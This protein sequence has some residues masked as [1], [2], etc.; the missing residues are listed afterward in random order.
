[1]MLHL[2]AKDSLKLNEFNEFRGIDQKRPFKYTERV[3]NLTRT[4]QNSFDLFY[5]VV[6]VQ[7]SKSLAL[8]NQRA[9][10][11]QRPFTHQKRTFSPPKQ[12]SRA[13]VQAKK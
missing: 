5:S 4:A 2:S 8:E 10:R 9:T 7:L 12:E 6:A 13:H 3:T 1:M 11:T